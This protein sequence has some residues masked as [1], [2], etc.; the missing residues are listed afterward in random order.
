M[1]VYVDQPIFVWRGRKWCHMW[2][3]DVRELHDFATRIGLSRS[4][5]QKPPKASWEHY[6]VTESK[7]AV[8]LAM[9]AVETDRY[10]AVEHTARLRG[11]AAGLARVALVRGRRDG[12]SGST[13]GETRVVVAVTS[14]QFSFDV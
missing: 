7:R 10:G 14:V 9:G 5:F 8:A 4:W 12:R 11:D 13:A 2:A 6:D 1:A 3:D